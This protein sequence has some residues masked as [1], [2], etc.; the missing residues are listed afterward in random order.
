MIDDGRM[1][2]GHGKRLHCSEGHRRIY[3][4]LLFGPRAGRGVASHQPAAV[5]V[6][7]L[8][9]HHHRCCYYAPTYCLLQRF[10]TPIRCYYI[11][12]MSVYRRRP[13]RPP[14]AA[15]GLAT[16]ESKKMSSRSRPRRRPQ[17]RRRRRRAHRRRPLTSS[18]PAVLLLLLMVVVAKRGPRH[19]PLSRARRLHRWG[20][21]PAHSRT[22]R[23]T[24]NQPLAGQALPRFA[25]VPADDMRP[26]WKA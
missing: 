24:D 20:A 11:L 19:A 10:S 18:P 8:C 25:F 5:A 2:S 23:S 6:F 16:F 17:Q 26:V 13:S 15:L 14:P 1:R 7:L 12:I 3:S 9:A 4:S 21:A 22:R